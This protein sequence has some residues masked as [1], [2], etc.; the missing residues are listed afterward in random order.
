MGNCFGKEASS[1]AKQQESKAPAAEKAP[2]S[3]ATTNAEPS[4]EVIHVEMDDK[5]QQ[6][7]PETKPQEKPVEKP[8][9]TTEK[10]AEQPAKTSEPVKGGE[11]NFDAATN[12]FILK[13]SMIAKFIVGPKGSTIKQISEETSSKV[14]IE[15]ID[16][17][18]K[19]VSIVS[20]NPLACYERI[21]S[22]LKTFGWEYVKSEDQFVETGTEAMK[23]FKEL[24]KKI[25][26]ES[27]LM[28]ECFDNSKKAFDEGNGA[29]A[30]QLS[31]EGK[32]HQEQMK[33]YQKES[34]D[35][36]FETLNKEKGELEI[37]LHGQYVDFAME[38]L[39]KRIETLRNKGIKQLTIIYGAGNHSDEKGPKIKPAVLE[40]LKKENITFEEV[41]HGSILANI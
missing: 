34:A 36:M 13:P 27:K 33:K 37:D 35:T 38:F 25:Q 28:S 20:D 26:E 29:L 16:D 11:S 8:A 19:K 31:E 40:Y 18:T 1:P 21:M 5:Q 7:T 41:N 3:G 22:T 4:K 23:L 32:Q 10:T 17:N 24:E 2:S 9:A 15:D 14:N 6:A 30:K 12:S 39:L